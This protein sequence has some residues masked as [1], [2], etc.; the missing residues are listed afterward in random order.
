MNIFD[1]FSWRKPVY[2]TWSTRFFLYMIC[3]ASRRLAEKT[4][5]PLILKKKQGGGIICA[6]RAKY[7]PFSFNV[8]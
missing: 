7:A 3:F 5:S 4:P 1:Y 2:G 8:S 6:P